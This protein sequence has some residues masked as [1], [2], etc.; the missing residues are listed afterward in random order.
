MNLLTEDEQAQVQTCKDSITIVYEVFK[1][2]H[3]ET[4]ALKALRDASQQ[5]IGRSVEDKIGS[6]KINGSQPQD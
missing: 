2:R 6:L 1:E 4:I 3:G 5:A